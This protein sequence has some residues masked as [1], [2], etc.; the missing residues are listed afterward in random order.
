MKNSINPQECRLLA[1]IILSGMCANPSDHF[2]KIYHLEET[3]EL[4]DKILSAFPDPD[5]VKSVK[6]R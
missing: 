3:A 5:E 4:L 1:A 6:E 2:P